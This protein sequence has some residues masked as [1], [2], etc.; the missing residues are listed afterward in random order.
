MKYLDYNSAPKNKPIY[1]CSYRFNPDTIHNAVR[2]KPVK[3]I[4]KTDPCGYVNFI[5]LKLDG[6]LKKFDRVHASLRVYADTEAECIE[7][8]NDAVKSRI[9]ELQKL[10]ELAESDYIKIGD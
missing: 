8:Y 4:L 5:E 1:A 6:G 3:G 2:R 7:L 9:S 10:V